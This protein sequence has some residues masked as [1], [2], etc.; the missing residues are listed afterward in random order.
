MK[1]RTLSMICVAILSCVGLTA[2][3]GIADED[4]QQSVTVAFGRGLNTAQQSNIVNNVM[5]PSDVE[6]NQGGVVHFLM[7]GFHQPAV[8]KPGT[9]PEDIMVP[10]TGAFIDDPTNRFYL[11][12]NPA[13][14]PLNT[15]ATIDPSNARNRVESVGFP[16]TEGIV[17]G[18]VVSARAEPGIYL[19][20]CNVKQHFQAGMFGFV[21]VKAQDD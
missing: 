7:A 1:R 9:K 21:K 8:Y 14:G 20:I 3:R 17:G 10:T 5:L 16:A 19:V 18:M 15:P 6:I 4:E 13:G 11:G 12:I 2:S